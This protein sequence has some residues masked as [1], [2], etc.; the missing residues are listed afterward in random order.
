[1]ISVPNNFLNYSLPF[2][3]SR[4][5]P[6]IST[7]TSAHLDALRKILSTSEMAKSHDY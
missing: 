2:T 4:A 6:H 7:N 1:M 3:P 5:S